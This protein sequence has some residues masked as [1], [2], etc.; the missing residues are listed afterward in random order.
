MSEDRIKIKKNQKQNILVVIAM[1]AILAG[2]L[3]PALNRARGKAK[4]IRCLGNMKQIS[5]LCTQYE[6]MTE[7]Y[8][9]AAEWTSA[10]SLTYL[11]K[12]LERAGLIKNTTCFGGTN[13]ILD[14]KA[15]DKQ[16]FFCDETEIAGDSSGHGRYG[17]IL[18]NDNNGSAIN[19][20]EGA[21]VS[22]PDLK[23]GRMKNPSQ[24][25]YGGDAGSKN[26][27]VMP[28]RICFKYNTKADEVNRYLFF[29]F[30]HE[31]LANVFWMDGH[32]STVKRTDIPSTTASGAAGRIP[33]KSDY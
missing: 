2:M 33:W 28:N 3:L 22:R 27:T 29:D 19:A 9:P 12:L 30:R 16:Y 5:L 7:Y 13:A 1:I 21:T 24:V 23:T 15:R 8:L 25:I 26:S 17:D 11:W 10:S 32:S 18:L 6:S 31:N 14:K 20:Y 4:T